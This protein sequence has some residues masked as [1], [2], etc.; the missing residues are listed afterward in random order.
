[1]TILDYYRIDSPV[2]PISVECSENG[3]RSISYRA[4]TGSPAPET[5]A[6][7]FERYFAGQANA[8]YDLDVDWDGLSPF[9]EQV[10]RELY[11]VRS[12][13]LVSYGGL[14]TRLGR[15]G[16]ARAVGQIIGR[17][18]LPIVVPCHR[19]VASDGTLGGYSGGLDIK[20]AL[21]EL[22]GVALRPGGWIAKRS[23]VNA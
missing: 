12:P 10:L 19:V 23:L 22:E 11:A 1:M 17:N 8:L 18:R 5:I 13:E 15:P 21:L 9:A 3:V 7:P 20:R 2:G 14:A 4:V 16:A 6:Q